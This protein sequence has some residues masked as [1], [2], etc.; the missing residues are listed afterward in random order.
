[1]RLATLASCS[2]PS[3]DRYCLKIAPKA[4]PV[5]NICHWQALIDA[6]AVLQAG[7]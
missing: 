1:M 3:T 2:G 5:A 4:T 6:E 7:F